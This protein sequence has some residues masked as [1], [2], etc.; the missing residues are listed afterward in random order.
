MLDTPMLNECL[1]F[2]LGLFK[3]LLPLSELSEAKKPLDAI[4]W[5]RFWRIHYMKKRDTENEN[6]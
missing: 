6:R 2:L 1:T 4:K 3:Y 5:L